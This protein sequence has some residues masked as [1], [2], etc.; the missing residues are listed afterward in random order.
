LASRKEQREQARAERE[1]REAADKARAQRKT[2]M[3]LL[4]GALAAAAAIV[5]VAIL[6]SSGGSANKGS[7][8]GTAAGSAQ[9]AQLLKGIPQ[10]GTTL[11]NPG[12]PVTL[13]EFA[14]LQC[15]FCREASNNSLPPLVDKYVRPGKLRIEFRNF[16]ILGPDSEKAARA[17]EGAA[18]Q[19][20]AW[21][22]I[23]LWYLNQGEENSGYVNDDFIGKIARGAGLDSK[24]VVAASN[25]MSGGQTVATANTEA[26][27]FGIQSTPSYLIA[28]TGQTP[29]QL[30][31]A[32]PND[33]TL[34]GQAIDKLAGGQ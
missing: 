4:G 22:F 31:I 7:S 14:D 30:Q 34:F 26:Q 10:Q 24:K 15:P 19:G 5:V 20:R 21:Q 29:T 1:A 33:P 16:A 3:L 27:K 11:G 12:A 9:A 6:I 8:A 28:R 13:L 32:D 2:R 25:D 23:D 17:L 18:D